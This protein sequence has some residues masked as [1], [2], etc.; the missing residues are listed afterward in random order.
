M[1]CSMQMAEWLKC[2]LYKC[3]DLCS[4]FI[5]HIKP[6]VVSGICNPALGIQKKADPKGS[7]GSHCN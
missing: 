2:F 6:R 3:E 7:L 5:S 4:V 1:L